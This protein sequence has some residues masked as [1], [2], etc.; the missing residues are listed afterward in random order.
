MNTPHEV[1]P[2]TLAKR[3]LGRI[4]LEHLAPRPRWE[5]LLKNYVFWGLGAL[6]AILG[7]LAVAASLFEI[8]NVDWRLSSATHPDRI[9]FFIATAPFLWLL[10]LAVCTLAGYLYVRRTKHGY[11]YP[12]IAIALGAILLALALGSSLY[13]L[14]FGGT[15]EEAIGDHPPFYR[16]I[17]AEERS[18][19]LASEKGLLGGEVEEVA[20]Q[21][22]SFTL[23]DFSGRAWNVDTSDLRNRDLDAIAHGGTV[24]VIGAPATASSTAFHACFVFPWVT[25]GGSGR[26]LATLPLALI[27]STS[28]K[29]REGRSDVCKGIRPY[30]QL[31][32]VEDSW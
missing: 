16:P 31:H 23:H 18:W 27:A 14:G 25:R 12:L 13:L 28:G 10:A 6:A 15:I 4:D 29:G 1:K 24:R 11:R 8:Q 22:A 3:V 5:F 7:A 9:S 26:K 19:W 21:A 32:N 17:L 30:K 2:H 20:P